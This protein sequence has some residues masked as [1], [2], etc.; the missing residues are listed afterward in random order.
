MK[1]YIFRDPIHGHI[2]V[3]DPT[4]LALIETPE[5]QRLRRIRQLG[6]SFISYHG[7]EHTRFA[8]SLGV[9]HLMSRV[10]KH[11]KE[12]GVIA[13]GDDQFAMATCA[14][15][16]HD[17]GHGPFSHLFEKL[18][19]SHH[20]R[21][22]ETVIT[23]PGSNVHRVLV[24]RSPAWPGQI[25]SLI[26]GTWQG[27]GFVKDLLSSQ[28]DVDRMDYL[29]RDS[30]MCGVPYGQFDLE[31]LIHTLTVHREGA[32]EQIVVSAK[33]QHAAEEFLLARYFMYWNVYFHKATRSAEAVLEGLLKRAI[34][35]VQSG[36]ETKLQTV[37]K[38]V[39]PI[40]RG[41][42]MELAD[43]LDLDETDVLYAIKS[44]ASSSDPV[45]ADLSDRFINRRLFKGF[46][47][48]GLVGRAEERRGALLEAIRR[49]GYAHPEYY[50]YTDVTS[51]LAYSYYVQPAKGGPQPIQVLAADEGSGMR[52]IA[53]ASPVL[54]G[55][56]QERVTR[57]SLFVPGEALGDVR[58]LLS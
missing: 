44:W 25:A 37:P 58:N 14:A 23:T 39:L 57:H 27:P 22:V 5:F 1:E 54:S 18:T 6:T 28:L 34:D 48:D 19:G 7:A 4:V 26:Q 21:W 3:T 51:N 36:Q 55:I 33:G 15:L 49:S 32:R 11:L 30:F 20:E 45:L 35:L 38:A 8:H 50:L 10:L 47:I 52:E 2:S 46:R 16:L 24:E 42:P 9:Y 13:M 40:L 31:R 53:S 12:R 29:L 17:I 43:Y 41:T 56:A